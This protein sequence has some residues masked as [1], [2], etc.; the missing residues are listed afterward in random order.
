MLHYLPVLY[1]NMLQNLLF[2]LFK[3]T[4]I[5]IFYVFARMHKHMMHIVW[6]FPHTFLKFPWLHLAF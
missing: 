5:Y 1:N 6:L 2:C 4:S 3:E